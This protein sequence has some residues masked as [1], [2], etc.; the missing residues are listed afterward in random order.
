[1]SANDVVGS[2]PLHGQIQD[3]RTRTADPDDDR[4]EEWTADGGKSE[5][6][7]K[8]TDLEGVQREVQ[9]DE[10]GGNDVLESAGEED[11]EQLEKKERAGALEGVEENGNDVEE[12]GTV[13]RSFPEATAVEEV[14]EEDATRPLEEEE[15]KE[16]QETQ[17]QGEEDI[18]EFDAPSEPVQDQGLQVEE[19]TKPE[20]GTRN[21]SQH[22]PSSASASHPSGQ[23]NGSEPKLF[24]GCIGKQT[25]LGQLVMLFEP[26]GKIVESSILKNLSGISK[27]CGFI[28]YSTFEECQEAIKHLH[29]QHTFPGSTSP[30]QVS[31]ANPKRDRKSKRQEQFVPRETKR[32]ARSAMPQPELYSP[33]AKPGYGN[34]GRIPIQNNPPQVFGGYVQQQPMQYG[35]MYEPPMLDN[36]VNANMGGLQGGYGM[37]GGSSNVN[38]G[39]AYSDM[40]G[41]GMGQAQNMG[42]TIGTGM[43]MNQP[44]G[45][46]YIQA[47]GYDQAGPSSQRQEKSLAGPPGANLFV[48]GLP[49]TFSNEDLMQLFSQCGQLA[50]VRVSF[51]HHTHK[52]KGY[53]FVSYYNTQAA[54]LAMQMFNGYNV[55]NK[56]LKIEKRRKQ[57]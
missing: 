32:V 53:G 34:Y 11:M 9:Q 6:E 3:T 44:A 4:E 24:V 15:R 21:V 7:R 30:I 38:M 28:T 33:G 49:D 35:G 29:Q 57:S 48:L 56:T 1:M 5:T 18:Q 42:M 31:L 43:A 16:K 13:A 37:Y 54:D 2:S 12:T 19:T 47:A 39:A 20:A 36:G 10:E 52:S 14:A 45:S 50:E 23:S 8:R 27:G 46:L 26:H 22:Q 41:A 25:T 40:L 51:D 55:G 17:A